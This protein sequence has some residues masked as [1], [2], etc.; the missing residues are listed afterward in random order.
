[1]EWSNPGHCAGAHYHLNLT[2][3]FSIPST[4]PTEV[5]VIEIQIGSNK[6]TSER[7]TTMVI[8]QPGDAIKVIGG[9]YKGSSG[10]YVCKRGRVMCTVNIA[11]DNK[12][13]NIWLASIC[14]EPSATPAHVPSATPT[15][16]E[17]DST[18]KVNKQQLEHLLNEVVVMKEQLGIIERQLRHLLQDD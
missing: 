12:Q 11:G 3:V 13:R 10:T 7:R 15:E 8:F 1:L 14:H 6:Q 16:T 17:D 18:V 4:T 9:K 5:R 2:S